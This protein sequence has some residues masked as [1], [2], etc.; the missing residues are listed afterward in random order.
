MVNVVYSLSHSLLRVKHL[1]MENSETL[2][3]SGEIEMSYFF[4]A[5]N[6]VSQ[7]VTA[8]G[9]EY[10]VDRTTFCENEAGKFHYGLDDAGVP[11]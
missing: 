9:E 10:T 5:H 11:Q 2:R 6:T 1:L 8:Q 7:R 3:V 4:P